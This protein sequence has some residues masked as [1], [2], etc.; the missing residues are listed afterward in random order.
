[1]A[2][3]LAAAASAASAQLIYDRTTFLANSAVDAPTTLDAAT[4]S[5]GVDYSGADLGWLSM[6]ALNGPLERIAAADGI[7]NPLTNAT[8]DFVLSPGGSDPNIK[9]DGMSIVFD[10]PVNAAGLDVIFDVPDG[11]SF[12][13]VT[14]F[15]AANQVLADV[16]A[17]PSPVGAP[18]FTFVGY[19]H[20]SAAIKSIVINEY[21][22]SPPDDNIAYNN[23]TANAVPEPGLLLAAGAAALLLKRRRQA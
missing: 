22:N 13:Q 19:V 8:G 6:T 14:F 20:S 11:F 1:M 21:D 17:I 3:S 7:R 18:G 16:G 4:L 5:G 12:T 9:T 2:L 15:D 10:T 23:I